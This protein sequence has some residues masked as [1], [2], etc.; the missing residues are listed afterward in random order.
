MYHTIEGYTFISHAKVL[1]ENNYLKYKPV[2]HEF[3][4][5]MG[6][7][8]NMFENKSHLT[9]EAWNTFLKE[10][11]VHIHKPTKTFTKGESNTLFGWSNVNVS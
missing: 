9:F 1:F 5:T 4:T 8:R 10:Y 6:T 3:K 2:W 7:L 11:N